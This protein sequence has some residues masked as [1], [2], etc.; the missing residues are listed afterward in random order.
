MVIAIASRSIKVEKKDF[1]MILESYDIGKYK[2]HKHLD[3]V[4]ASDIYIVFTTRGKFILKLLIDTDLIHYK[5][6]LEFIDFLY[7]KKILVVK[8]I[9]DKNG[10]EIITYAKRKFIVQKFIE[11]MHP[12]GF[13]NLLIGD[14]SK[15]IGKMHKVLLNSKFTKNKKHN[16]KKRNFSESINTKKVNNIQNDLLKDLKKIDSKKLR[17]A[18]IHGDLSEVNMIIR[19]NKLEAFIDF[20]DSDYDYLVYE[21]AIFIAHSFVRSD[22]IY[23]DKIKLFLNS[24]QKYVKLN[25]EELE[26]I[27]YLIKYRLL[28]ILHWHFKYIRKYPKKREMLN[29]GVKRSYDRLA[30]FEKISLGI[31]METLR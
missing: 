19:G 23:W 2:S 3:Y 26:A 31:F 28:G 10:N 1:V 29:K 8:N 15:N 18:R 22:I 17:V 9:K 13:S 5:D 30:S 6:Q 24:Y 12:R 16:Y 27:Y 14:I 21:L 4:L 20:D 11:G 25:T 7:S